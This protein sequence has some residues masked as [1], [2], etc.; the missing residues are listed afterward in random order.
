[1]ATSRSRPVAF[2]GPALKSA[3]GVDAITEVRVAR[4]PSPCTDTARSACICPRKPVV[5]AF[6]RLLL[7]TDCWSMLWRAPLMAV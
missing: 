6:A 4:A 3:P 5:E 1:M 7:T 2:M